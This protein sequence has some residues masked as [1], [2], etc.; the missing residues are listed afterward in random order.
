MFKDNKKAPALWAVLFNYYH[1]EMVTGVP[2]DEPPN[3]IGYRALGCVGVHGPDLLG[4][5]SRLVAEDNT[6]GE[7]IVNV[8]PVKKADDGGG[9]S[10][11]TEEEYGEAK[12]L[13]W[14]HRNGGHLNEDEKV[15]MGWSGE[16]RRWQ[17]RATSFTLS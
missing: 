4:G 9:R 17:A 10:G 3:T 1:M 11:V 15:R 14:K 5:V 16:K 12:R 6:A 7:P 13:L 8:F 2:E